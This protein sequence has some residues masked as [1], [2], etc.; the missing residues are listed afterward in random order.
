MGAET[1]PFLRLVTE[2]LSIFSEWG[3]VAHFNIFTISR[4][5]TV[6]AARCPTSNPQRLLVWSD[7]FIRPKAVFEE[8]GC[9]A[10]EIRFPKLFRPTGECVGILGEDNRALFSTFQ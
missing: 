6:R 7:Q 2:R 10:A 1:L 9:Y 8:H 3:R 5:T 4:S